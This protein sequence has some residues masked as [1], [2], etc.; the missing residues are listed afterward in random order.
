MRPICGVVHFTALVNGTI[1]A[2]YATMRGLLPPQALKGMGL[3]VVALRYCTTLCAQEL[4]EAAWYD[5]DVAFT[6]DQH[7]FN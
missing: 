6:I 5:F 2:S 4:I 7:I 1:P 3:V